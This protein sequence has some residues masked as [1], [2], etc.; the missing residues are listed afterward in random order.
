ML[1]PPGYGV[2]EM[3]DEPRPGN[4]HLSIGDTVYV[5]CTRGRLPHLKDASPHP[6]PALPIL[7][8]G[9][10]P[11]ALRTAPARAVRRSRMLRVSI[12]L[13]SRRVVHLVGRS[14]GK[15]ALVGASGVLVNSLALAVLYQGLR[16]PLLIASP[17]SVECAIVS[18]FLLND[19]WT[20]GRRRP[21]VGR[22][23]KF[24]LTMVGAMLLTALLVWG[25][26]THLRIQYL[27]ANLLAIGTAG[28][29]NFAVSSAWI[30]GRKS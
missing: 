26:V 29:L 4:D 12:L 16:L 23:L 14:L 2:K 28:L 3:E 22:F 7:D 11:P 6:P 20:F 25:F 10:R 13:L 15:F 30:W 9:V 18:N 8:P 27:V 21:T 24:N 17:I 19:R 5:V 1:Y